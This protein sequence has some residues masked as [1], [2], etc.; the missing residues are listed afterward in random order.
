MEWDLNVANMEFKNGYWWTLNKKKTRIC[1]IRNAT[2]NPVVEMISYSWYQP[3]RLN[4]FV[5]ELR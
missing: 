5:D 2:M 1:L 4:L 3:E